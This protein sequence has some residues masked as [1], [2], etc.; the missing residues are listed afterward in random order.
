VRRIVV[1]TNVFVAALK[2]GN[3][4]SRIV[5]RL[6]L[7][8]KCKP[9]MGLNLFLEYEDVLGRDELFDSC[10][11]SAE[12]RQRLFAALAHV[13]DGV[14]VYYL[15]RPNLPDEGDNHLMGLAVA[16]RAEIIVTQNVRDFERGELYFPHIRVLRPAE[17]V[18]EMR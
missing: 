8:R 6:C 16:G 7:Q 15:W 10:P 17:F 14:H 3:G 9:L 4:A 18:N 12:E 11:L 13:S 5:L 1:D 2:S